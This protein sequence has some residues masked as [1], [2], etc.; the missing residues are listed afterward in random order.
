MEL[1]AE[2]RFCVRRRFLI[3]GVPLPWGRPVVYPTSALKRIERCYPIRVDG[4]NPFRGAT[5]VR[6]QQSFGICRRQ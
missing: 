1:S 3:L 6:Q 2:K 5:W 4:N